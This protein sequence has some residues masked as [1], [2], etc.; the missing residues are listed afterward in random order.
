MSLKTTLRRA[1]LCVS[2]SSV[3]VACGRDRNE[4]FYQTLA[5]ANRGG[6]ITRGWIPE[7]LMPSSSRAIH[8]VEEL[9]PSRE[10]CAF[11]LLPTDSERLQTNLKSVDAL[12]T[13]V[14][15]IRSPHVSW[16]TPVLE[17]I[18][19]LKRFTRQASN[20]SWWKD[21]RTM[22]IWA[23]TSLHSIGRKGAVSSIGLSLS[24]STTDQTRQVDAR[25]REVRGRGGRP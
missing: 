11:E 24:G 17:E 5:D 20:S 21:P 13:T 1:T 18:W 14:K 25:R 9:S 23:S 15:H 2:L 19:T 8:L 10:W 12:P 6:E 7:E 4:G 3:L 22:S 16:W